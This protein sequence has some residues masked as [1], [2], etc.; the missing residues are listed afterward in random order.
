LHVG[1]LTD[2]DCLLGALLRHKLLLLFRRQNARMLFTR[3]NLVLTAGEDLED[4]E[5]ATLAAR[6]KCFS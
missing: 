1:Y 3:C 2:F 5:C 4:L 6:T